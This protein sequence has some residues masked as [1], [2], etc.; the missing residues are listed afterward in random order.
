MARQYKRIYEMT[1]VDPDGNA[2]IIRE[3]RISFEITKSNISIPNI[4]K[5]DLY[6]PSEDTLALL[7]RKFT[8]ITLNVGYEGS[9]RLVF[10][11]E[12][13]NIFQRR[14]G[15]DRVITIYS[16]DGQ[17]DWQNA[18]FNKAY[19]SSVSVNKIIQDIMASFTETGIGVLDGLPNVADRLLGESISGSSKD[20]LDTYAEQYGFQWS[21]QDGEIVTAPIES[22]L[23]G[24]ESVL[25][26]STSGMI[27][28]PTITEI[29]VDVMTLLN[30]RLAPNSPFTI[31]SVSTDVQLGNLFFRDVKRTVAEGTYKVMESTFKG[32]SWEGEWTSS[33]KGVTIDA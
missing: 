3:L 31:E 19:E 23:S 10:T 2:R 15:T 29:G 4:A 1:I 8:K 9:L 33:I 13:R 5:I 22:P 12:I 28:S 16:A 25:I 30:P 17:K 27:G 6:N 11:G 21:I 20:L 26:S 14:F 32:D 18:T 24:V 7:Q